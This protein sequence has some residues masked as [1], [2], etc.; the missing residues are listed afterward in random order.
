MRSWRRRRALG[1]CSWCRGARRLSGHRGEAGPVRRNT[2]RKTISK[3]MRRI[4]VSTPFIAPRAAELVTEALTKGWIS[5]AGPYVERFEREFASYVG[6]RYGVACTS[7]T[8]AL[9][10][11]LLA[12]GLGPG[13]EVIVP[14]QTSVACLNA[15]LYVGAT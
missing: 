6:V 15:V 13:D 8:A 3:R 7:G 10:L 2:S 5:S 9:H 11:A 1:R 12:L 4:P 14:A